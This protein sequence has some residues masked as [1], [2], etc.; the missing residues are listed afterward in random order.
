MSRQNDEAGEGK[1]DR[2]AFS[3]NPQTTFMG[4]KEKES[5]PYYVHKRKRILFSMTSVKLWLLTGLLLPVSRS[6]A[7]LGSLTLDVVYILYELAHV[8]WS[9][10][11]C[12]L[13]VE[14][15]F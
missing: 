8:M 10:T 6:P 7:P 11:S 15:F 9:P 12:F 14:R 5:D 2:R 13:L 1:S 4:R 3:D